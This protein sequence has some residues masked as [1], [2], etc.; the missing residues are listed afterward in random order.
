MKSIKLLIPGK[1]M[2][3]QRPRFMR[4][5]GITYTP[6]ETI[7]Y[8]TLV[9]Q[10]YISEFKNLRFEGPLK[11]NIAAYFEIPKSKSKKVHERM[12]AGYEL[13]TKKPDMDNIIK[14]VADALNG[15]AYHDD[16][17]IVQCK[18]EKFYTMNPRVEVE[19]QELEEAV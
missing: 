13:P 7:N 4:K 19:I 14:I 8:E 17:Q 16:S 9:Q 18:V 1:P 6:K 11:M 5:T 3:K 10:L 15:I 12:L 2:G